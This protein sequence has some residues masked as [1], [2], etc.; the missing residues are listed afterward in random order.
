L[1]GSDPAQAIQEFVA[2]LANIDDRGSRAS[3]SSWDRVQG[4]IQLSRASVTSPAELVEFIIKLSTHCRKKRLLV[5]LD[6]VDLAP[7][8]T[9]NAVF[10]SF[11]AVHESI[12]RTATWLQVVACGADAGAWLGLPTELESP[13]GN[14]LDRIVL[15]SLD[16]GQVR[17]L[18]EAAFDDAAPVEFERSAVAVVH[19]LTDGVPVNVQFLLYHVYEYAIGY[20]KEVITSE[21][22]RLVGAKIGLVSGPAAADA[23]TPVNERL[24]KIEGQLEQLARAVDSLTKRIESAGPPKDDSTK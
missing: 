19:Q 3:R 5:M 7:V 21:M 6:N 23:S 2:L 20:G 16:E 10:R 11:R 4:F 22:V 1:E 24:G 9:R 17:S 15:E 8:E 14:V 12:F 13:L 18:I